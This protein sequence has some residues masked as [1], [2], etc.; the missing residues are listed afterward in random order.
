MRME[1]VRN[2]AASREFER[3]AAE[4]SDPLLRTG[5]LMTGER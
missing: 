3:F 5:F 2:R 4:A 1:W